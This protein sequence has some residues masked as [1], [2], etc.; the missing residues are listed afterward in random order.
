MK[1][2]V[3]EGEVENMYR[4]S[5]FKETQQIKNAE[6]DTSRTRHFL[7]RYRE[8]RKKPKASERKEVKKA[9]Q[10]EPARFHSHSLPS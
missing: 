9:Y 8:R 6:E 7:P 5:S 1:E 10:H 2:A 4:H 3:G